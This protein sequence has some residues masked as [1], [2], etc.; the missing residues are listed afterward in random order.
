MLEMG[1][2]IPSKTIEKL[3]NAII[4]YYTERVHDIVGNTNKL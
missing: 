1:N 3:V 2:Y 4:L